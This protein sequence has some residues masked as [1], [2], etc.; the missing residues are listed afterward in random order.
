MTSYTIPKVV[1][2]GKVVHPGSTVP[3]DPGFPA[4]PDIKIQGD[5][6]PDGWTHFGKDVGIKCEKGDIRYVM[7]GEWSY[8]SQ[9]GSTMCGDYG[10]TYDLFEDDILVGPHSYGMLFGR[11]L[12]V[13]KTSLYHG[14]MEDG[15]PQGTGTMTYLPS[16]DT[17]E[18]DF[19]NGHRHGQGTYKWK[20]SGDI[21]TGMWGDGE[22]VGFGVMYYGGD[23]R[24]YL[25][26]E[27]TKSLMSGDGTRHTHE[28]TLSCPFQ[29]NRS[30]GMGTKVYHDVNVVEHGMWRNNR[31]HGPGVVTDEEMVVS[32][33]WRHGK[34]NGVFLMSDVKAKETFEV[35]YAKNRQVACVKTSTYIP[36]RLIEL[37]QT[38]KL[39]AQIESLEHQIKLMESP[40][41]NT[42]IACYENPPSLLFL[43]CSH[44]ICCPSCAKKL[45][46]CPKCRTPIE[47]VKRVYF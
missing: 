40:S 20:A 31:L 26:G 14:D 47:E 6:K 46:E 11:G 17:F 15:F 39:K 34:K 41:S 33:V 25:A 28:Y 27:W 24:D 37:N 38:S 21:F 4:L 32:G 10:I 3:I 12:K 16:Q 13:C 36:F 22:R 44:M 35:L 30:L 45:D 18:G 43:P 23:K 19:Y 1:L 2:G 42:C 5:L 8:N 7:V 9:N 29:N